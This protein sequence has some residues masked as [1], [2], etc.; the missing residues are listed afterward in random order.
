[1]MFAGQTALVV[2]GSRGFGRGVVKALVAKGM[3]VVALARGAAALARLAED[4]A[5]NTICADATDE[6]EI[7]N[8]LRDVEPDL[9]VICA[10]AAL[11]LMPLHE[12]TWESFSRSWETDTKISFLWMKEIL[13]NPP[14]RS[15]HAVLFGSGAALQGSP[16]SGGYSG[17]KRMN[18]FIADYA[19]GAASRLNLDIRVHCLIPPLSPST[20]FGAAA[21]AA[22]ALVAGV[23]IDT[24]RKRL[25]S[26]AT[27]E[28]IGN[29]IV[30]LHQEP[31]TWDKVGYRVNGDGLIPI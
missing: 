21:A 25:P 31:E 2:G 20:D 18:A 10:G 15:M 3:K 30:T 24:F 5:V 8:I 4:L 16:L 12:H 13:R 26:P 7:S 28:I 11:P 27:P 6:S 29:A 23:D 14:N 9:L 17:A 1:M 19:A 22:Y